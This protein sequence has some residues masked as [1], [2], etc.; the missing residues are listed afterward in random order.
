[1]DFFF[2]LTDSR[3]KAGKFFLMFSFLLAPRL[4][5]MEL[6]SI[7]F[8]VCLDSVILRVIQPMLFVSHTLFVIYLCV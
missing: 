4:V 7:E 6:F 1:M 3:T 5:C 8:Q 2:F